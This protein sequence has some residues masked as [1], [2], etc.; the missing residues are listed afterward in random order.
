MTSRPPVVARVKR[1]N[2]KVIVR[3]RARARDALLAV[4]AHEL[5]TPLSAIITSLEVLRRQGANGPAAGRT[6]EIAERQARHMGRLIEEL[7]DVSRIDRGKVQLCKKRLDLVALA[8]DAVESVSAL[9]EDRNHQLELV[10]P[11][12]PLYLDADPMRWNKSSSIC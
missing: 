9:I 1:S 10:L 7:L 8:V 6:R 2:R 11:P 4:L 3:R 12:Q 5:R